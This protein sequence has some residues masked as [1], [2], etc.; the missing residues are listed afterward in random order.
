METDP[1]AISVAEM[2]TNMPNE[3]PTTWTRERRRLDSDSADLHPFLSASVWSAAF[4]M[5]ALT[6]HLARAGVWRVEPLIA[7]CLASV[8]FVMAYPVLI[9]LQFT[10]A[11]YEREKETPVVVPVPAAD[12]PVRP[13][14]P[15]SSGPAT[16]RVG[17]WKL[18]AETWRALFAA[19]QANNGK[20][21]RDAADDVLPREMYRNWAATKSELMRLGLIDD[22]GRVTA[23][24]WAFYRNQI[25]PSPTGEVTITSA[26]ST[27]ARRAP[28]L[29]GAAVGE[30]D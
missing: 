18:A 8:A 7:I 6:A 12:A 17:A 11:F 26:Q 14:I 4:G 21:T 27:H 22:D 3:T 29:H 30:A 28:A 1:T 16:V 15:S 23:E 19:A 20:L 24:G 5:A 10:G 13:F 2:E 25:A 9:Y